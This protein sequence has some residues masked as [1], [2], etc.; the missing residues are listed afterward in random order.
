M[1]NSKQLINSRKQ[2]FKSLLVSTKSL[3]ANGSYYKRLSNGEKNF[4]NLKKNQH[5]RDYFL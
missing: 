1:Q 4:K 3:S 2:Y 5:Q